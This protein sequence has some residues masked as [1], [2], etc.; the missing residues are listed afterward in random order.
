MPQKHSKELGLAVHFYGV[1][2][3][4]LPSMGA[5]VGTA[6]CEISWNGEMRENHEK[7]KRKKTTEFTTSI[8]VMGLYDY[9]LSKPPLTY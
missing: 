5:V 8:S 9:I 7:G 6:G 4:L 2:W 1:H 3:Q